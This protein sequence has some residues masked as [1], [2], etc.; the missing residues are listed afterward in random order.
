MDVTWTRKQKPVPILSDIIVDGTP[1]LSGGT[2]TIAIAAPGALRLPDKLSIPAL[3]SLGSADKP[4]F[5][6]G[7]LTF[8]IHLG[9]GASN[10]AI[11]SFLRGITFSTK[12]KGLKQATRTLQ[13]TLSAG[14]LSATVYRTVHVHNT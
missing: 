5:A 9:T 8:F 2:L 12:G 11:Q 13:A 4:K 7:Q 10:S 3:G 6:G 14:G 1:Q